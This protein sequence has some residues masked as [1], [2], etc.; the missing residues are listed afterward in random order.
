MNASVSSLP[1]AKALNALIYLCLLKFAELYALQILDQEVSFVSAMFFFF[2]GATGVIL[3]KRKS[4]GLILL[5]LTLLLLCIALD[6]SR[7]SH[8]SLLVMLYFVF[9]LDYF[10]NFNAKQFTSLLN[11]TL[12]L[13]YFFGFLNKLN[14]GFLS[15]FV[16]FNHSIFQGVIVSIGFNSFVSVL[17]VLTAVAIIIFEL[18]MSILLVMNR[19]SPLILSFA[20]FFH[21]SIVFIMHE[22]SVSIFLELVIFN[23]TCILILTLNFKPEQMPAF[24]VIWDSDCSFCKSAIGLIRRMDYLGK[25]FFVPNSDID[26]L[27]RY[28]VSKEQSQV[29]MHVLD[30]VENSRHSGFYGFRKISLV[31]VPFAFLYPILHLSVIEKLGVKSY[32]Y[33]ALRRSCRLPS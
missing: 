32:G 8:F 13:V 7:S 22:S 15:G 30:C 25:L 24:I 4:T 18:L 1:K 17:L 9:G 6:Y 20:T 19:I 16:I 26:S 21:L 12:A 10:Q 23:L 33:I 14:L 29:S 11:F 28:D 31:L 27:V 3:L 2:A 5:F